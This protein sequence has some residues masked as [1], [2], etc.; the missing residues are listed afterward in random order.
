MAFLVTLYAKG[1]VESGNYALSYTGQIIPSL[2]NGKIF[3][4]LLDNDLNFE[5]YCL[6]MQLSVNN[7]IPKGLVKYRSH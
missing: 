5:E 2:K 6:F 3:S 7:E 1:T 4:Q